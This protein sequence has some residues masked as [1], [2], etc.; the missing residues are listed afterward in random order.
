[1]SASRTAFDDAWLMLKS[2]PIGESFTKSQRDKIVYT[3]VKMMQSDDPELI[4]KATEL[5]SLY[6]NCFDITLY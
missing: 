1:M 2:Q 5:Y 4:S 6:N 3:I